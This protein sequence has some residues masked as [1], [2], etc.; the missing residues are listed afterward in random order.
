[1]SNLRIAIIFIN[2]GGYHAA[3]LMAAHSYCK[4][5]GWELTAIQVTDDTLEHPWGDRASGLEVRVKTLLPMS[6][7]QYD[8]GR[9]AFSHVAGS[10]LVT[11]LDDLK[12]HV[13]FLPGWAF[14]VSK[15]GL[16]W[17]KRSN[18]K[19]IV[20]SESKEDDFKRN[21]FR[22]FAKSLIVKQ[23][24]SALVGGEVHAKYLVQLGMSP[25]AIFKGY[26][27]VDN[28]SYHPDSLKSYQS[29][30]K[31]PYFLAI[32]RFI[33]KKNI[34]FLISAYAQYKK[35]LGSTAWDLAICGDG[36]LFSSIQ[37]NVAALG[38]SQFIHLPGFLKEESLR[39]YF[40][41]ARCFIHASTQ[42]QWG[43]VVNEAMAAALPVLVSTSCGCYNDL[44]EEG[45]NGYG[46]DPR[47][48]SHLIE[49]M[50]KMTAGHVDSYK[51]GQASLS[52]IQNFSPDY[53]G[54][55]FINAVKYALDNDS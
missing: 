2:I 53:F 40:A 51:M 23:Y 17:C 7:T 41:H 47:N 11:Y 33:E 8:T 24:S 13:V 4:K 20:M 3:R 6:S 9:D 21:W 55:G 34:P 50:T 16:R 19:A 48:M 42:E 37:N 1:M 29:P 52:K 10:A 45:T 28:R 30:L 36:E 46:F 44:V 54:Q 15:A 14:S 43:L 27:I 32:S 38:L 5:L 18:S 35:H 49:L 22:E 39:P 31:R 25:S 26:D 12:P